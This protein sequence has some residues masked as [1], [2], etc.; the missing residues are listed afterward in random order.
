METMLAILGG[1]TSQLVMRSRVL[2]RALGFKGIMLL[3]LIIAMELL[4]RCV[5]SARQIGLGLLAIVHRQLIC[6]RTLWYCLCRFVKLRCLRYFRTINLCGRE[7]TQVSRE[8]GIAKGTSADVTTTILGRA[9]SVG[10]GGCEMPKFW[11]SG[12]G[13]LMTCLVPSTACRSR[14]SVRIL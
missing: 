14:D 10:K 8:G 1:K 3:M 5:H 13:G 9:P 4:G 7:Q 11:S 12:L 6:L 2:E